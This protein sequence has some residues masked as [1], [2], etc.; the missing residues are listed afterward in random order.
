[1]GKR[2]YDSFLFFNELDLLEI[3]LNLLDDYVDYFVVNVSSPN[4][5]GLRELQDKKPLSD[6]LNRLMEENAKKDIQKPILL[7][8]APDLSDDQL[9]D[10]VEIVDETK[11]AGVKPQSRWGNV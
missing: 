3:R 8:I 5:P 4:T 1:M 7:K 10:I 9:N 11:I 2:H 6:I